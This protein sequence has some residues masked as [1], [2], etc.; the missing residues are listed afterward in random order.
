[1]RDREYTRRCLGG[2]DYSDP[3][4]AEL[5]SICGHCPRI[6]CDDPL[7]EKDHFYYA[8]GGKNLKYMHVVCSQ[9]MEWM[10]QDC[11]RVIGELK[12]TGKEMDAQAILP[13]IIE[14]NKPRCC[15]DGSCFTCTAPLPKPSC[16][17][18]SATKL[19]QI[20]DTMLRTLDI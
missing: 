20:I 16:V 19:L 14:V 17:L 11:V 18:D 6:Y 2:R 13:W 15:V 8:T 1:M 5:N 4:V 9:I 7:K 3:K 12:D 10:R